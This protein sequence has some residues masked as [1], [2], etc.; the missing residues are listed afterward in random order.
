LSFN[1]NNFNNF[2][3]I[4]KLRLPEGDA[5]AMKYVGLLT[6]RKILLTLW[7]WSWTFTV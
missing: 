2:V 7:P 6:I 1:S 5:D 3:Q 4:T